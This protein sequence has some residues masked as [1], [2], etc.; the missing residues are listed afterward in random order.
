M[1]WPG[2]HL[3]LP[4]AFGLD[5]LGHR[6]FIRVTALTTARERGSDIIDLREF[7]G[8][9]DRRT[10]LTYIRCRDR[11]GRS[12]GLRAEVLTSNP[13]TSLRIL[14]A[15]LNC[16]ALYVDEGTTSIIYQYRSVSCSPDK[17]PD[18]ALAG[19]VDS[20]SQ[21]RGVHTRV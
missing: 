6:A 5:T 12:P 21:H 4:C 10:A 3:A 11:L 2:I 9:V 14:C 8:H 18:E 15:F 13:L 7:A 1:E 20:L 16:F 17:H 19:L